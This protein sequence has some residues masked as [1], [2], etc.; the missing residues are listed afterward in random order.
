MNCTKYINPVTLVTQRDLV[1]AFE[2]MPACVWEQHAVKLAGWMVMQMV[3]SSRCEMH[4]ACV[5]AAK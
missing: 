3:A 1:R 4:G 2:H 5:T